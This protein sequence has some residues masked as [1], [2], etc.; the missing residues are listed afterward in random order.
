MT[1]SRR[2]QSVP[3][4]PTRAAS[5]TGRRGGGTQFCHVFLTLEMPAAAAETSTGN[6][7]TPAVV[8]EAAHLVT[9]PSWSLITQGCKHRCVPASLKSRCASQITPTPCAPG[10]HW[11]RRWLPGARAAASPAGPRGDERS[12]S[13]AAL[14]H[15]AGSVSPARKM[16]CAW[17]EGPWRAHHAT[18]VSRTGGLHPTRAS[19]GLAHAPRAYTW[20]A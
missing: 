15:G 14:P 12:A 18:G 7:A 2:H 20:Y 13:R 1:L 5:G 10:L 16:S 6:G 4:A 19:Q 9:E 8:Q 17:G 3:N 11:P